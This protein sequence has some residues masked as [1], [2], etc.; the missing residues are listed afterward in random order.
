MISEY[1]RTNGISCI[2]GMQLMGLRAMT[3]WGKLRNVTQKFY[4]EFGEKSI[5]RETLIRDAF[6]NEPSYRNNASNDPEQAPNAYDDTVVIRF[7]VYK[8]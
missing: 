6:S 8:I 3:P 2:V 5:G 1:A 7:D 4:K